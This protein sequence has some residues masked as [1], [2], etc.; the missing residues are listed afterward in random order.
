MLEHQHLVV[1][2]EVDNPPKD[3]KQM[4]DWLRALV[5][6]LGMKILIGPFGA[7]SEMIGNRGLTIGAIIETSHVVLHAWDEEYPYMMQLDVYSC[8]EVDPDIIWAAMEQF[9]PTH[10]D[11]KFLNRKDKFIEFIDRSASVQ[12]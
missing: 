4:E 2:A 10:I 12:D 9:E 7:Y 11:H 8:S 6:S 1:R 3:V 5:D